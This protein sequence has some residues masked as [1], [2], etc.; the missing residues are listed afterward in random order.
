MSE[1][2]ADWRRI[3]I[4]VPHLW[5]HIDIAY[6]NKACQRLRHA[7]KNSSV[8]HTRLQYVAIRPH[9]HEIPYSQSLLGQLL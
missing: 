6:P 2:C 8:D 5:S 7:R 1:V 9:L 3:V 4:D